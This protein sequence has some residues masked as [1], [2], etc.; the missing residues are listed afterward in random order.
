MITRTVSLP[1]ATAPA[2][3]TTKMDMDDDD[4]FLYGDEEPADEVDVKQEQQPA[5][6]P[7]QGESSRP[8]RAVLCSNTGI[9]LT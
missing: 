3:K 6:A 1:L 8:G 7:F 4:A 5:G 2:W 9:V